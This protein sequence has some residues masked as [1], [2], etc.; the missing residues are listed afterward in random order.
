MTGHERPGS[1]DHPCRLRVRRLAA[2]RRFA[3]VYAQQLNGCGAFPD[4]VPYVIAVFNERRHD[5]RVDMPGVIAATRPVELGRGVG[6]EV[7]ATH[8]AVRRPFGRPRPMA[9]TAVGSTMVWPPPSAGVGIG[10][11]PTTEPVLVKVFRGIP[12][13]LL[14]QDA[15]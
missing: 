2:S 1:A 15:N 10:A 5:T 13:G 12:L 14:Q 7:L 4:H 3:G 11:R 6:G 8:R 9:Q